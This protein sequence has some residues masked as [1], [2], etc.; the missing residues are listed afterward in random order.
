MEKVHTIVKTKGSSRLD[1][2]HDCKINVKQEL[3][4]KVIL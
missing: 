2:I 3:Y 4:G 1:L